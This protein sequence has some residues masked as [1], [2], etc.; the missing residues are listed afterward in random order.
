[1]SVPE[2]SDMHSPL[3]S[4]PANG[5]QFSPATLHNSKFSN[6][7]KYGINKHALDRSSRMQK[8]FCFGLNT[9]SRARMVSSTRTKSLAND[10]FI[11]HTYSLGLKEATNFQGHSVQ[12][13]APELEDS[14]SYTL[15]MMLMNLRSFTKNHLRWLR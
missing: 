13:T 1:M 2:S 15:G 10:W 3:R 7:A 5:R 11:P 8:A 12:V 14:S 4:L 9:R 6:S